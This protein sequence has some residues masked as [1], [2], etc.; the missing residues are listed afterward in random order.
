MKYGNTKTK[1]L[2]LSAM[3]CAFALMPVLLLGLPQAS[4]LAEEPGTPIIAV[5][6]AQELKANL[7]G[8]SAGRI[9][10]L[11]QDI[12]LGNWAPPNISNDDF[13]LDGNGHNITL[14]ASALPCSGLLAKVTGSR[15]GIKNLGVSG[16]VIAYSDSASG[17]VYTYAGGLIGLA[18]NSAVDVERTFFTNSGGQRILAGRS[19]KRSGAYSHAG[20]FF[21]EIRNATVNITDCYVNAHIEAHTSATGLSK[22]PNSFGGGLV[23]KNVGSSVLTVKRSYA[24]GTLISYAYTSNTIT[25]SA[26]RYGGGL[27]GLKESTAKTVVENS[28]RGSNMISWVG[29]AAKNEDTCGLPQLPEQMRALP[30]SALFGE[31]ADT[32]WERQINTNNG[33][34]VLLNVSSQRYASL[35]NDAVIKVLNG[36]S[37]TYHPAISMACVEL[38]GIIAYD[39][40]LLRAELLKGNFEDFESYDYDNNLIADA[41]FQRT[42]HAFAKRTVGDTTIVTIVIRGTGTEYD[43]VGSLGRWVS[44]FNYS[45]SAGI[46]YGFLQAMEIIYK[47][48]EIYLKK[49]GLATSDKNTKFLITGSSRG[50]SVGNILSAR[51]NESGAAVKERVYN[52]NFAVPNIAVVD[53]KTR[54]KWQDPQG[55]YN[56]IINICN[57]WDLF[58]YFPG[59]YTDYL[60]YGEAWAKYGPTYWF[61]DGSNNAELLGAHRPELYDRYIKAHPLRLSAPNQNSETLIYLE[62]LYA[63]LADLDDAD[64]Y[65]GEGTAFSGAQRALIDLLFDAGLYATA[66]PE[67]VQILGPYRDELLRHFTYYAPYEPELLRSF[68]RIY[69]F[70]Y[71]LAHNPDVAAAFTGDPLQVFTHFLDFGVNEGRDSVAD[72]NVHSYRARYEDLQ[73][74]FGDDLKMYYIHYCLHGFN[75]GRSGA[76]LPEPEPI[77]LAEPEPTPLAEPTPLPEPEPTPLA[78]PELT[79]LAEPTSL[80]EPEHTLLPQAA[81]ITV[82]HKTLDG[83]I[84][85]ESLHSADAG[86]GYAFAPA[87]FAYC[88]YESLAAESALPKGIAVGGENINITFL[89]KSYS[90]ITAYHVLLANGAET[91]LYGPEQV[92]FNA[93][94]LH[95][96]FA[97]RFAFSDSY[98]PTQMEFRDSA[99]QVIAIIDKYGNRQGAP[100]TP[101][102]YYKL[103]IWYTN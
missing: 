18:E 5:S 45:Q 41:L 95:N 97:F 34:P 101:G 50:A 8:G 42:P 87:A 102:E 81:A 35:L 10:I 23:G 2:K 1:L 4:L 24:M 65:Y 103:L 57:E 90:L 44:N 3:L 58:A 13:T 75:E 88:E 68:C 99:G 48:L 37:A 60:H 6:N 27:V 84:L 62:V 52:Y 72:W 56:N 19:E 51:L 31:Y 14:Y 16:E 36:S 38:A 26:R 89:Y 86:T 25:S 92:N 32:V 77:P 94:E 96:G 22:N 29:G 33:Y 63:A 82:I 64:T 39:A 15:L 9:I 54:D 53:Y 91:I 12:N 30:L 69:D 74:A 61:K 49:Y 100:L 55:D 59:A 76:P 70:E 17:T 85:S 73:N 67:V 20:G 98:Q 7:T 83:Y 43:G 46:H 78:E 28:Y 11:E 80:P 47:N 79:P 40:R 93:W 66:Q 21:G 71:Y